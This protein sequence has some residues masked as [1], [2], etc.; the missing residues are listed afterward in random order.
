[1]ESIS[2]GGWHSV[3]SKQEVVIFY[4]IMSYKERKMKKGS[5]VLEKNI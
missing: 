5:Q 4:L 1:M 3:N 2:P